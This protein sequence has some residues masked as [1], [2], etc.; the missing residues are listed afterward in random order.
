MEKAS[1]RRL[2]HKME[3]RY[4]LLQ[5]SLPP[6]E[7]MV[8]RAAFVLLARARPVCLLDSFLA[9]LPTAA[10]PVNRLLHELQVLNV[11]IGPK[12][13]SDRSN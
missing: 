13:I 11:L 2:A 4:F 7:V 9:P 6:R 8:V 10:F 3:Y 12:A 5:P 1:L